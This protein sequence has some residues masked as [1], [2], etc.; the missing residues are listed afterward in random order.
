MMPHRLATTYAKLH[1]GIPPPKPSHPTL[2]SS[3]YLDALEDDN[4]DASMSSEEGEEEAPPPPCGLLQA[5]L[6]GSFCWD[7]KQKTNFF[8]TPIAHD[9]ST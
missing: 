6:L 9:L 1:H 8:S 3:G 7:S 4:T 2:E 5:V